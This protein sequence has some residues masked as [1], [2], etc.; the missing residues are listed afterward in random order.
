MDTPPLRVQQ[1][2]PHT[3]FLADSIGALPY[4]VEPVF[5]VRVMAAPQSTDGHLSLP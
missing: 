3:A 1:F 5:P 2:P 4:L